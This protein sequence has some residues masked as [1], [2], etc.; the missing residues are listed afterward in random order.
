MRFGRE[1]YEKLHLRYLLVYLLHELN[2][3]V[4]QLVLQHLLGV[5]VRN[6]ERDIITLDW[7]PPQNDKALRSLLQESCEFVDQDVLNLVC[8]LD[9]DVYPHA[10]DAGLDQDSLVFVTRYGEWVQDHFRRRGG[11]DLGD[12]VS[13]GGLRGEVGE[14]DGGCEGGTHALQVRAEGLGLRLS[15]CC[16]AMEARMRRESVPLCNELGVS[17]G[18]GESSC[19]RDYDMPARSDAVPSGAR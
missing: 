13:F 9:L 7:F 4:H 8:L 1:T 2:D 18:R 3:E 10:V 17:P 5:E 6:Q 16:S 15:V 14:R 12:I 11:F 19:S